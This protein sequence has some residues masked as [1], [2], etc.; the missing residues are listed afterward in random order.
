M[1]LHRFQM[2]LIFCMLSVFNLLISN[3]S[4]YPLKCPSFI[5]Y[6]IFSGKITFSWFYS[7]NIC[8][9]NAA[10]MHIAKMF[11]ARGPRTIVS[12][13]THFIIFQSWLWLIG[14]SKFRPPFFARLIIFLLDALPCEVLLVICWLFL[15]IFERC[16]EN[17]L[18]LRNSLLLWS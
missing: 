2:Y 15:F 13:S 7:D 1:N 9:W 10:Q 8:G 11:T 3:A 12:L 4:L 18:S 17:R 6:F 5:F 16:S 14:F